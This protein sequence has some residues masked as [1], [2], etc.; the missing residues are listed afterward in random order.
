MTA[1]TWEALTAYLWKLDEVGLRRE[2]ERMCRSHNTRLERFQRACDEAG[3]VVDSPDAYGSKGD[4][5]GKVAHAQA[6]REAADRIEHAKESLRDTTMQLNLLRSIQLDRG[7]P[8]LAEASM[9]ARA[10]MR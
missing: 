9:D 10:S 3:A 7:W 4:K 8:A 5:L 2:A 6:I 1:E